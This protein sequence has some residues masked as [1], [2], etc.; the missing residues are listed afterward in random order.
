MKPYEFPHMCG[1][2]LINYK[3]ASETW[4]HY[5]VNFKQLGQYP[6]LN[7]YRLVQRGT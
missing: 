4:T 5:W 1:G 6:H 2:T 3:I 7:N